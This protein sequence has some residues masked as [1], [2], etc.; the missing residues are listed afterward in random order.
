[1]N[2]RRISIDGD[3][4]ESVTISTKYQVVIPKAVREQLKLQPGQKLTVLLRGDSIELVPEMSMA[5]AR[6]MLAGA[7]PEGY[8]DRSD[9]Y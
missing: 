8:R 1:M 6:G 5:E 2:V 3:S 7:N 4:V 9:R